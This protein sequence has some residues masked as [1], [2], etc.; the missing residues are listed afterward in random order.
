MDYDG[1]LFYTQM[2]TLG[3][4]HLTD[5]LLNIKTLKMAWD[6]WKLKQN[7][8]KLEIPVL[9]R[10][11]DESVWSQFST[12]SRIQSPGR[13]TWH[14]YSAWLLV[15]GGGGVG[16]G[17]GGVAV[18]S[19]LSPEGPQTVAEDHNRTLLVALERSVHVGWDLKGSCEQRTTVSWDWASCSSTCFSQTTAW[20]VSGSSAGQGQSS[21]IGKFLQYCLKCSIGY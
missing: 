19:V 3:A 2:H 1:Y 18:A 5:W 21:A 6:L 15:V 12:H 4:W 7:K 14:E 8:I 13:N 20:R 9:D 16:G 17:G 11:H 10:G